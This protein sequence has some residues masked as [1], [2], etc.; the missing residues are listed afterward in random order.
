LATDITLE[1]VTTFTDEGIYLQDASGIVF[2]NCKFDA[3]VGKPI[4]TDNGKYT[5]IP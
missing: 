3:A 2:K 1:N 5:E 4:S